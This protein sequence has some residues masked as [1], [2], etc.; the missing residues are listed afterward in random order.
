MPKVTAQNTRQP[1]SVPSATAPPRR[2]GFLAALAAGAAVVPL[3]AARGA[4]EGSDTALIAV[5]DEIIALERESNR[6]SAEEELLP[7]REQH[8]F[9]EKHIRPLTNRS[10]D[11]RDELALT[12]ATTMAG[13]RAKARV[14][15]IYTNCT[16]GYADPWQ[17]DGPAWSLAN[18][19]LGVPSVWRQDEDGSGE[20]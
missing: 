13:Y 16:S 3:V 8:A 1:D 20:A 6:L 12:P 14:L 7:V 9:S 4:S 19:L 17:D 18:D 2:R 5:A 15:Q 10:L 11:L